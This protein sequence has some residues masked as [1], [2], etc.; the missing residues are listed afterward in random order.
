MWLLW[1]PCVGTSRPTTGKACYPR[2]RT[3][4]GGRWVKRLQLPPP[5][6]PQIE[7]RAQ[8][9][10]CGHIGPTG[11]GRDLPHII[12]LAILKA[13]LGWEFTDLNVVAF[14][15]RVTW[16]TCIARIAVIQEPISGERPR[17]RERLREMPMRPRRESAMLRRG[18]AERGEPTGA[19]STSPTRHRRP[20]IPTAAAAAA[21]GARVN[22]GALGRMDGEEA[23]SPRPAGAGLDDRPPPPQ[24]GP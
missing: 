24:L 15:P 1:S 6:P 21:R 9:L 10:R 13:H 18:A 23:A 2:S 12:P 19:C 16:A 20:G 14:P 7:G 8:P 22:G 4:G 5:S 3:L 17:L 11:R